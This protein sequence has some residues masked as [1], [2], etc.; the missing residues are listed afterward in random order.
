MSTTNET[1]SLSNGSIVVARTFR[2]NTIPHLSLLGDATP[3]ESNEQYAVGQQKTEMGNLLFQLYQLFLYHGQD[4]SAELLWITTPVSGQPFRATINLYLVLRLIGTDLPLLNRNAD[5]MASTVLSSLRMQWY[6]AERFSTDSLSDLFKKQVVKERVVAVKKEM[7][8]E[9]L[10]PFPQQGQS[11]LPGVLAFDIIP[12]TATPLHHIAATLTDHPCCALSIQL[13]PTQLDNSLVQELHTKLQALMVIGNDFNYKYS[14]RKSLHLQLHKAEQ[15]ALLYKYYCDHCHRPLFRFNIT[16]WGDSKGATALCSRMAVQL[17]PQP[18]EQPVAT[19]FD[20]LPTDKLY[21]TSSHFF[22]LPWNIDLMANAPANSLKALSHTVTTEEATEFFCLPIASRRLGA[23]FTV[24][25]TGFTSRTYARGTV[26]QSELP[27]GRMRQSPEHLLGLSLSDLTKHLLI[28]GTPGS[29]KSNFSVGLLHRLWKDRQVP[30]LVIEPAKSEYRAL[31][32]VLSPDVRVFTPGQAGLSPFIFN[33]FRPPQG[34]TLESYRSVLVTAFDA[35]MG[36]FSPLDKIFEETVI[37]C[38]AELGWLDFNTVDD[39]LPVPTIADFMACFERTFNAIGYTD[40]ML[41]TLR[42]GIVRLKNVASLFDYQH[43]I[44]I[45]E[46]LGKPAVIELAALE[47][48]EQKSLVIALL[49][50]SVLSWLNANHT[51]DDPEEV[52]LRNIILLEE[53]HVLLDGGKKK[54]E[55]EAD[56]TGVAQTLLKRMLAELRSYG[57]GIAVADQSPRKVGSDIV[58]LTDVKMAFR[59]VEQE[60]R[61]IIADSTAMNQLQQQRLSRLRPG[62]AFLYYGKLDAAEEIITPNYRHEHQIPVSI[63]DRQLK[64]FCTFWEE[65]PELTLPYPQCAYAQGCQGHPCN[66]RQ[67]LLARQVAQRLFKTFLMPVANNK[68]DCKETAQQVLS[69]FSKSITQCMGE[70][71]LTPQLKACIKVHLFR[72]IRY[73]TATDFS[74]RDIN[75]SIAYEQPAE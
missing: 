31:V 50:L 22:L 17:N 66:H 58:A 3:S 44:P 8:M 15:M 36:L 37:N 11:Q 6:G 73:E 28:V 69:T 27:L 34:V 13:L 56:P 38:Y 51:A 40:K 25:E 47:N 65:H 57:V 46:L 9:E 42:A 68:K 1:L 32:Q 29:G 41:N 74:D 67:R 5:E 16:A 54:A 35:S 20:T 75:N 19:T 53:A 55:S 26:D 39:G 14:A 60:D 59:L 43:S 52:V 7:R 10:N 30:F 63:S 62:E 72:L 21:P 49:L 23:G 4:F 70:Q 45:D 48:A 33:P 12:H 71:N 61:Q 2:I 64:P 18:L 24:D